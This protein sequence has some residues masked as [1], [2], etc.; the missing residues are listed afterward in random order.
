VLRDMLANRHQAFAERL[1]Q[2][3]EKELALNLAG[4]E[5]HS[6]ALRAELER[7]EH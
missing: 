2:V 1:P 4:F 7:A 6:E 5:Q 3:R